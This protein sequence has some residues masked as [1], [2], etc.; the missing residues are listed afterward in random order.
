MRK[1]ILPI[2]F[3]LLCTALQPLRADGPVRNV[4]LTMG[5]N[6]VL[7]FGEYT[8]NLKLNGGK[9]ACIVRDTVLDKKTFIWNGI[10]AIE[11]DDWLQID[12]VDLQDFEKCIYSYGVG[13]GVYLIVEGEEY[14]PYGGVEYNN[15]TYKVWWSN[16]VNPTFR[17]HN[18]FMFYVMGN[19]FVHDYDGQTY[20]RDVGR[21]EFTSP[22]KNHTARLSADRRLL[23][24]D[25][26]NYVMPIPADMDTEDPPRHYFYLFDNGECYCEFWYIKVNGL[27]NDYDYFSRAYY[28]TKNEVREIDLKSEYFDWETLRITTRLSKEYKGEP[29]R[30][31][32]VYKE[33]SKEWIIS[34][35]KTLHDKSGRHMFSAHW[36]YD[37]VLIDGKRY[38]SSYPLEA[39]YDERTDTF[40]WIAVEGR[41][42]VLYYY[43]CY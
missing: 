18:Y 23:T 8:S 36:N 37:Y 9:Y 1:Y 31:E 43:K 17:H 34:F 11:S 24:I 16:T 5:Y 19:W 15:P 32:W 41:Q 22:S 33:A 29:F 2:L 4:L 42:L 13:D 20:K 28:V 21:F 6:E 30:K 40:V 27:N 3:A 26:V 12:Y 25:G 7:N 10:R 38:G 35:E 14:G 39:F